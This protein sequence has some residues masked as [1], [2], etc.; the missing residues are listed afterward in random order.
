MRKDDR[1][2]LQHMLDAAWEA[3][4]FASR[5][6]RADLDG[7][8]ISVSTCYGKPYKKTCPLWLPCWKRF[9]HSGN[10]HGQDD[11]NPPHY[12]HQLTPRGTFAVVEIRERTSVV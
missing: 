8:S 3:V 4:S 11:H 6:T 9:F 2:R 1:V 10:A 12:Q 7:N 5:R